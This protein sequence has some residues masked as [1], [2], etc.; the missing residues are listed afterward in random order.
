M[1]KHH[2]FEPVGGNVSEPVETQKQYSSGMY[3][4]SDSKSDVISMA[5][6]E[7][8]CNI[9]YFLLFFFFLLISVVAVAIMSTGPLPPLRILVLQ[10]TFTRT[11]KK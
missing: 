7:D 5:N 11:L 2:F 6:C 10:Y 8:F 4:I 9:F 1:L 3:N